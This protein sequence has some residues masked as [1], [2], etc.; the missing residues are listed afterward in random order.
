MDKSTKTILVTGSTGV[1]GGA[2]ARGLL[3]AGWRVRALTRSTTK[4]AA[5]ALAAAGAE[6]VAGDMDDRSSLAAAMQGVYGVYSVQAAAGSDVPDDFS[7]RDEAERGISVAEVA[8][9]QGVEAFVYSSAYGTN[10]PNDMPI[11]RAKRAIE[12]RIR[13]L[14]LPATVIRPTTFME[15]FVHPLVGLRKGGTW[16]TVLRPDTRLQLTAAADIAAFVTVAFDRRDEL[17]GKSITIAG[18]D[19]TPPQIVE[20]ISRAVGRDVQYLQ[21]PIDVMRLDQGD[22][23]ADGFEWLNLREGGSA[24]I[25]ALRELHPGLRNLQDWLNAGGADRIRAYLD[26]LG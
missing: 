3:A 18:D 9:E 7:W 17:N 11:L 26:G 24:D 8:A 19:L 5:V 22:D 6:V 14:A 21:V 10:S 25:P 16:S 1:Q 23:A 4:P 15:N 12:H 20:T 13:D 2:V